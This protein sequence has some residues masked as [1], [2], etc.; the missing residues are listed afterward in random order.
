MNS[1]STYLKRFVG[2]VSSLVLWYLA[3]S[4]VTTSQMMEIAAM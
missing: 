3:V 4:V 1:Q 2:P